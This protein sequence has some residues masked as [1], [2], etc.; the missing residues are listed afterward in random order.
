MQAFLIRNFVLFPLTNKLFL[1]ITS[2][3]YSKINYVTADHKLS[4]GKKKGY[5]RFFF[6]FRG[7]K[8]SSRF[9]KV[10]VFGKQKF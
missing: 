4:S 3:L 2:K 1:V 5:L 9:L 10:Q 7:F 6:Y 8:I